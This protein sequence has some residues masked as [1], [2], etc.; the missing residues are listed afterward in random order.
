LR[1]DF[2]VDAKG[3]GFDLVD[4]LGKNLGPAPAQDC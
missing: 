4:I 3:E 2:S 1:G